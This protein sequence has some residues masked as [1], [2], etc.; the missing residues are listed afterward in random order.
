MM[1]PI[2]GR[3]TM[4]TAVVRAATMGDIPSMLELAGTKRVQYEAY[5]PVFHRRSD[6]SAARAAQE[7]YFRRL[8][9][10]DDALVL[11]AE[12][13]KSVVGFGTAE[14]HLALAVYDPGGPAAI[15][16]DFC[17]AAP[18][19]WDTVG[20]ELLDALKAELRKRNVAVIIVVCSPDDVPKR[21]AIVGAGLSAASEWFA[22]ALK[23]PQMSTQGPAHRAADLIRGN[24]R[25]IGGHANIAGLLANAEVLSTIGP[26]IAQLVPPGVNLV[27]SLEARGFALG[28][29]AARELGVG[30]LLVRKDGSIH[31]GP[32]ETTRTD[33]DWRGREINLHIQRDQLSSHSRVVVVDD[34][35]QTGSQVRATRILIER[36]GA[37]YLGCACLVADCSDET[38]KEL[39]IRGI[40]SSND[41][42][43]EDQG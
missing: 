21:H 4:A 26:A 3:M 28:A 23:L 34:W 20:R 17:V 29:L 14:I 2:L 43:H 8:I 6:E 18:Q 37:V 19:L 40:V 38:S 32:K 42:A 7:P 33:P 5:E 27:A 13:H 9:E 12:E 36:A 10:R 41:L 15:V 25:W 11:V 16:D 24:F 35:V 22:Q 31:P 1:P 39:S 30:L